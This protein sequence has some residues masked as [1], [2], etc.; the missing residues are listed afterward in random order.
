MGLIGDW[1]A[2]VPPGRIR[3]VSTEPRLARG[4]VLGVAAA[5]GLVLLLVSGRY[6]YHRDER[7]FLAAGKHLA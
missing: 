1:P 4:P 5:R 7:Y 3:G 6:G 2:E